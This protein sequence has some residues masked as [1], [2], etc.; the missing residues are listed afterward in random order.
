MRLTSPFLFLIQAVHF[1][2]VKL[3]P[4]E[5]CFGFPVEATEHHVF[6]TNQ[7]AEN[8]CGTEN[9][10]LP[11]WN[12]PHADYHQPP[13][14]TSPAPTGIKTDLRCSLVSG[15]GGSPR[16][17]RLTS[18][19][20]FLIQVRDKRPVH[21]YHSDDAFLLLLP[22][23]RP[24]SVVLLTT[25]HCFV[26][27]LCSCGDVELN[28]GPGNETMFK[29]ILAELNVLKQTTQSVH[30]QL[31]ETNNRIAAIEGKLD[32]LTSTVTSYSQRVDEMQKTVETLLR[33]VDDLENR[34][35]RNN[36]IVYGVPENNEE[37]HEDL[38]AIVSEKILND[39]LKVPNVAIERIHRLGRPAEKKCRPLIFK[40]LNGRDKGRILQNCSKLKNTK[41]VISE[42]FSPRVQSIRKKLWNSAQQQKAN[43]AKVGLFFDKIKINGKLFRW[44]ETLEER[45]PVNDP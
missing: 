9:P 39:I 35:R 43:G 37:Q 15:R 11:A 34:S 20:L 29:Q 40:L 23:P 17:M 44:D 38:E 10:D 7:S 27:L 45:V 36:L 4:G 42:D 12:L 14:S 3:S 13:S 25:Y 5:I 16:N 21:V 32:G 30:Q 2:A 6:L 31:G 24:L 18:P 28:P 8:T 33:K 41:Y 1:I 22:C 26:D 19:F